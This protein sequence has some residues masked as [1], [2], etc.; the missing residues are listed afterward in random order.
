MKEGALEYVIQLMDCNIF[1]LRLILFQEVVPLLAMRALVDMENALLQTRMKWWEI[2]LFIHVSRLEWMTTQKMSRMR[3]SWRNSQDTV[4][5]K[6][7]WEEELYLNT[8]ILWKWFFSRWLLPILKTIS[9]Q[10]GLWI[11]LTLWWA[12]K[13]WWP[14]ISSRSDPLLKL[15]IFK[16]DF[17]WIFLDSNWPYNYTVTIIFNLLI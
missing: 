11:I 3:G 12:N 8:Y 15:S 16:L 14:R 7:W 5:W 6:W 17:V 4:Y 13:I 2:W 1:V 10:L 9:T